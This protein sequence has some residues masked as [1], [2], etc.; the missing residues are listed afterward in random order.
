MTRK[1]QKEYAQLLY[2]K[3]DLTQEEIAA[4]TG[5]SRQTV[6]KWIKDGKWAELKIGFTMTR[7]KQILNF[8]QQITELNNKIAKREEGERHPTKPEV[9]IIT[10][11]TNAVEKLE[12]DLGIKD[13]ITY[14][15]RVV[16]HARDV[17][18]AEKAQ[19]LYNIFDGY[20]KTIL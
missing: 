4:R 1:Q 17:Y 18:G 12:R 20:I 14:G 5:V 2:T 3:E 6:N 10:Q 8:S 19:E 9:D 11:L 7:E 16:N 13:C 15:R